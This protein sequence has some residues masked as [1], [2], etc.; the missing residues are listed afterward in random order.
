MSNYEEWQ[1]QE[2][3]HLMTDKGDKLCHI[4]ESDVC[5]V[6]HYYIVDEKGYLINN[7]VRQTRLGQISPKLVQATEALRIEWLKKNDDVNDYEQRQEE[8]RERYLEKAEKAR[9]E[10][11]AVHS[12]ARDMSSIIPLG[13]PILVGHHSER[14]HRRILDKI[15][16]LYRK[17]F[18]ECE[19]K[20]KHYERKAEAVGNGG[21]SGNDPDV[22]WKLTLELQ[23]LI[24]N[25][26]L[27]KVCNKVIKKYHHTDERKKALM[28]VGLKE[29]LAD[30]LL[31]DDRFGGIGYAHFTLS[32]NSAT[33]R[34]ISGRI[35]E[36]KKLKELSVEIK[37][38]FECFTF[39]ID[40]EDNRVKFI[41]PND[42]RP[43]E[44]IK[45]LLKNKAFKWSPTR[46]SFVRQATANGILA[47][48]YLKLD[49]IKYLDS[50]KS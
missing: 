24:A 31:K 32:N 50:I 35:D 27:M 47:G 49:I 22:I 40:K 29:D 5:C 16:N 6:V 41:F 15:D 26:E 43:D 30:K 37:E 46:K 3:S 20:A 33:I 39:Q 14:R 9:K 19:N 28:E 38:E 44:K 7:G 1:S 11:E 36:I 4:T 8:R 12:Q 18:V 21:I 13:Q 45:Q 25:Q 23:R 17:A 34:R 10:R 42:K 2:F 48:K